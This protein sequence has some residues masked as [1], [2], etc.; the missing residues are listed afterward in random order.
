MIAC[1]FIILQLVHFSPPQGDWRAIET[2]RFDWSKSASSQ[3][4]ILET[5]SDTESRLRIQT[6]GQADFIVSI[7]DG[8]LPLNDEFVTKEVV[9]DNLL[10]SSYL[11]MAPRLRDYANRPML[12]V[13]GAGLG[14]SPGSLNVIA[15]DQRGLPVIVLSSE[16]FSL[17]AIKD[18][19]GDGRSEIVG[20]HCL[21]QELG[22]DVT[23]Y[24]PYSVYRLNLRT[25][26]ASFSLA[27][28]R[29][30]NLK[31]YAWAGPKCSEKIV[32]VWWPSKD[33]PRLMSA[34]RASRLNRKKARGNH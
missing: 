15:L 12:V 17:S 2:T 8:L 31:N 30:Y 10:R 28:S 24:D 23:T 26:K 29:A 1:L 19:D 9:T 3:T 21:S 32:A 6:P 22:E 27:L 4:F 20:L 11:Y 5:R 34:E 25:G 33:K 14:S 13:F 7:P 16:E 18:L